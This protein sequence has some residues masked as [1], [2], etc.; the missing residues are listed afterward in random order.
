MVKKSRV[1]LALL[2]FLLPRSPVFS[3]RIHSPLSYAWPA[4]WSNPPPCLTWTFAGAALLFLLLL[5]SAVTDSQSSHICH[6][7]LKHHKG[8]CL[9]LDKTQPPYLVPKS[10]SSLAL[11][12]F[13]L[14]QFTTFVAIGL[15]FRVL[16]TPSS[17][18][19]QGLCTGHS[20]CWGCSFY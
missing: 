9:C 18:L 13:T 14:S 20:L 17:F 2:V 11:F 1:N 12:C 4:S 10:C 15:Y 8:L 5:L 3:T 6:P 16:N 7:F 19:A